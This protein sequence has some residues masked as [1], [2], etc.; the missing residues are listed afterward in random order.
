M[1]GFPAGAVVEDDPFPVVVCLGFETGP[2]SGE[3]IGGGVVGA[4]DDGDHP[5]RLLG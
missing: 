3:H 5:V 4:G 1:P 2:R